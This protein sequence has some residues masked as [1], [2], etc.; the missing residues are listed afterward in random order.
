MK[1]LDHSKVI[2]LFLSFALVFSWAPGLP[3]FADDAVLL[4]DVVPGESTMPERDVSIPVSSEDSATDELQDST[5]AFL[6]NESSVAPSSATISPES[7]D[8]DNGTD[9]SQREPQSESEAVL[10]LLSEDQ[11]QTIVG[12]LHRIQ[13]MLQEGRSDLSPID[14][15]R[16]Y[17]EESYASGVSPTDAQYSVSQQEDTSKTVS[18]NVVY[19]T[20]DRTASQSTAQT[21]ATK[22]YAISS[23]P[24]VRSPLSSSNSATK[25]YN[26]QSTPKIISS[27]AAGT[28]TGVVAS[29]RPQNTSGYERQD[30]PNITRV[31]TY[32]PWDFIPAETPQPAEEPL[33]ITE[34]RG[35]QVGTRP[36]P[37]GD[38]VTTDDDDEGGPSNLR[39]TDPGEAP[40]SGD[41]DT[42]L[43]RS[44]FGSQPVE[45]AVPYEQMSPSDSLLLDFIDLILDFLKTRNSR[46]V[47]SG[48]RIEYPDEESDVDGVDVS[49][50]DSLS[51][52]FLEEF[53]PE[54]IVE[55]ILDILEWVITGIRDM[56][57]S[58]EDIKERRKSYFVPPNK[59]GNMPLAVDF[60]GGNSP[61]WWLESIAQSV[62]P[63]AYA[64][65]MMAS[66]DKA[67]K[68]G[69]L[70]FL[71]LGMLEL[72]FLTA[73]PTGENPWMRML[74]MMQ[75]K[76][77]LNLEMLRQLDAIRVSLN[78][79]L[80][81]ARELKRKEKGDENFALIYC[82]KDG[83]CYVLDGRSLDDDALKL[84]EYV[85]RFQGGKLA[86][87][88]GSVT[89]VE[90]AVSLSQGSIQT[91]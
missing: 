22:N 64:N 81:Q 61:S 76:N 91:A 68:D 67:D 73:L 87:Y 34:P 89:D 72:P 13:Y 52:F 74:Y 88:R 77:F 78:N 41:G 42:D 39:E 18:P 75:R 4:T 15:I 38:S 44:S 55:A 50:N 30:A 25:T 36:N 19:V 11:R 21:V 51:N 49:G 37:D 10:A 63:A 86:L 17:L 59:N 46:K 66:G 54:E 2:A 65:P 29:Y 31:R 1:H 80:I 12:G 43:S 6:A 79:I 48:T 47:S 23:R 82:E 9:D 33:A 71:D 83:K 53:D 24:D 56:M 60:P 8:T 62:I 3:A 57:N 14:A 84:L 90:K 5:I 40:V 35:R 20:P 58:S 26:L 45:G 69:L 85:P 32:R 28:D 27:P 70:A 16:R 7:R